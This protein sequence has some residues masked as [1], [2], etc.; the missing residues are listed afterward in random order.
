MATNCVLALSTSSTYPEGTP[1]VLAAAAAL[2]DDHF[3]QSVK[4]I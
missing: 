3:E 4:S 1:A 2:L